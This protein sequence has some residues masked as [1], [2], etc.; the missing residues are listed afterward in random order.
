A[1]D[2][3]CKPFHRE[4]LAARVAVMLRIRRLIGN[5]IEDRDRLLRSAVHDE[6]TGLPN[7]RYFEVRLAEERKRAERHH[8]PFA[9]VLLDVAG[10]VAPSFGG[11]APFSE[12]LLTRTAGA[13]RQSVREGDTIARFGDTVFAALLTHTHFIGALSAAERVL[14]DIAAALDSDDA[15]G[16][17]AI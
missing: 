3:V 9:C 13:V 14:R 17:V 8:Q 1:D 16:G 2:Y 6:L 11:A 12:P 4:E 10:A 5:L 7:R 15:A